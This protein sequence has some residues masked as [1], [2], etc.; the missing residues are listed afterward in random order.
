[1][2]TIDILEGKQLRDDIPDFVAGDT[3]RVKLRVQE[4]GKERIQPIE[5]TVLKRKGSGARET[6]TVRKV[7][8]GIGVERTFPLHSPRL[9]SVEV[10]KRGDINRAKL[11]YL[12]KKVGKAARVKEKRGL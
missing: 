1:M 4:G 12:R 8:H 3:L 9:Q 2:N 5:G 7:A 6:F 11:Y 10:L